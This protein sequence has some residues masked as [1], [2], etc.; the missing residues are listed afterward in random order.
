MRSFRLSGAPLGATESQVIIA[1]TYASPK[2]AE[3]P[4]R[5]AIGVGSAQQASYACAG[6]PGN[7]NSFLLQDFEDAQM[8]EPTRE[9]ASQRQC[10]S[11]L[12]SRAA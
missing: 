1:D 5:D 11:A 6:D 10:D 7:G 12:G 3:F 2:F 8:R 9:T 4:D